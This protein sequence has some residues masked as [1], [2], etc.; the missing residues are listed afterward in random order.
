MNAQ[1]RRVI[2][3]REPQRAIHQQPRPRTTTSS[4]QTKQKALKSLRK[5]LKVPSLERVIKRRK[6]DS[7]YELQLEDGTLIV[8]GDAN[9]LQ[10]PRKTKAALFDAGIVLID[11]KGKWLTIL[12]KI[13]AACEL[14]ELGS[15]EEEFRSLIFEFLE[16]SETLSSSRL[17]MNLNNEESIA[18]LLEAIKNKSRQGERFYDETGTVYLKLNNFINWLN[19]QNSVDRWSKR[20]VKML[21]SR[22]GFS[23]KQ[24]LIHPYTNGKRDTKFVGRFWISPPNYLGTSEP[25]LTSE[26]L[27]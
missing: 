2:A 23:E 3:R 25:E 10:T 6:T 17:F 27:H 1:V 21:L 16:L 11:E 22:H 12:Q 5:M 26:S 9:D 24:K 8:L 20:D 19:T 7:K 14:V 4:E 15:D 13:Q 18:R